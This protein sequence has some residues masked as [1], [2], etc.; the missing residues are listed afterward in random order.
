MF[1]VIYSKYNIYRNPNQMKSFDNGASKS[2]E[3]QFAKISNDPQ[4]TIMTVH[5]RQYNK[6]RLETR[7]AAQRQG[8]VS[9]ISFICSL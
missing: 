6:E 8:M 9:G 3:R 7:G 1:T 2:I 4:N 5:D